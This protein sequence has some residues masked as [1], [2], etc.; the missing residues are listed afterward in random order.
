MEAASPDAFEPAG[1]VDALTGSFTGDSN[2][3][4]GWV[5]RLHP[6]RLQQAKAEAK[7]IKLIAGTNVMGFAS[8]LPILR[9]QSSS[10]G[11]NQFVSDSP[12]SIT[13]DA[14]VT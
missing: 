4:A 3:T 13:I 10:G 12:P 14:P 8:A 5:K 6:P 7:P 1:H 9:I 2:Q 11:S